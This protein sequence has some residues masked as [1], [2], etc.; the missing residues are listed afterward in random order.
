MAN[1]IITAGI[2]INADVQGAERI[3][4]L[5]QSLND[6]AGETSALAKQ[7]AQLAQQW[8][9]A[10]QNLALIEQYKA[11]KTV[12]AD[13]RQETAHTEQQMRQLAAQMKNGA[14]GAQTKQYAD[15]TAQL[16]Q[17]NE[18]K[19]ALLQNLRD[20]DQAMQTAG[21]STRQLAAQQQQF[22]QQAVQTEQGL[23][24]LNQEAQKLQQLAEAKITLGIDFDDAVR[25]EIERT[26]E[27]FERLREEGGLSQEE[28]ARATDAYHDKLRAL[29]ESLEDSAPSLME[30]VEGVTE[31]GKS[32]GGLA[33]AANE[34]M[35]FETAMA[36]VKKVTEG[37]P[38][39]YA[40]LSGSI[41]DLAGQLGIMPAELAEIAA[42]GGQMGVAMEKLPEFTRMAA[43]MSVAFG[44]SADA[45]G[46]MAAK[47]S[48][49]FGLELD[50]MTRLGD[51]IN[52]L[53][54]TTAAAESEIAQVLL[55]MGGSAKQFGLTAE[56]AAALGAAFVSLGKTPEV[57]GTAINALLQKLQNAKLGTAEFQ[58]ALKT[59]GYSA[60]SMAEQINAAPQQA[61]TDFLAKLNE[62]DN[63]TK[64]ETIGQL[65]GAEYADDIA[66]LS[67][68]LKTY[69]D[70][71]TTATDSQQTFGAMQRETDAALSTTAKR[72]DQ[73]K[74]NIA[75]AAIEMGNAL[76]PALSAT[77]AG[78]GEVAKS[79]G[80]MATRFP[81]ITQ[82]AVGF[83]AAKTA[84]TAYQ[85]AMRLSGQDAAGS[86]LKTDVGL[87]ALRQSLSRTSAAANELRL[88]L[89]AA[90]SGN[91]NHIQLHTNAVGS[92]KN[93]LTSTA[94]AAVGLWAAWEAGKGIGTS[95][96]E[97]SETVRDLGDGLGKMVAYVDAMFSER[98]FDD[99]R[100]FYR[101]SREEAKEAAAAAAKE[102]EAKAKQAAAQ[103]Q[104][105]EAQLAQIKE[106]QSQRAE[107]TEQLERNAGSLKT[108]NEAGMANGAT[109]AMLTQQNAQ[110]RDQLAAVNNQ[111]G[112]LNVNISDT[113]ALAKNKLALKELGL[114]AEQV[115]SGISQSA[116]TALDNFALA[117][118]QFGTDADSMARIFQAALQKMDSPEAVQKLKESLKSVGAE[119]GLTAEQ[120]DSIG[121]AAPA[122][123]DKVA[124]AFAKIGV[125]SAAVM[126]GISQEGKAAMDDFQAALNAAASQGI[127]DNRLLA[128]G[129]EQMMG[130][131]KS[132]EEFA[133]FKKQLNDSGNAA[134]LTAE[135][136]TRLNLAAEQGA[137]AATTAYNKLAES[138]KAAGNTAQ[139]Q[140]AG[141][142]AEQA[143]Q[144][145]EI[146][147]AQYQEMLV[148]VRERTAELAQAS[149][150]AGDEARA[151]H[152]KAS[153]AAQQRA[154]A[155]QQA[156]QA[157][158]KSSE[159]T[160]QN[161]DKAGKSIQA[162]TRQVSEMGKAVQNYWHQLNKP[163]GIYTIA[164]SMQNE[165]KMMSGAW[166]NYVQAMWHGY[167]QTR[168][169]IAD[170][171]AATQSGVGIAGKLAAAE[172]LAASNADKLDKQTLDN[173]RAAIDDARQKM[174]ALGDEAKAARA[175][176][177]KELL[178]LQGKDTAEL[179]QQQKLAKLRAARQ[180]AADAGNS[181]AVNDYNAGLAAIEQSYRIKKQQAQ[182]QAAKAAQEAEQAAKQRQ[183][184]KLEIK[185][186]DAPQIDVS[187][188]D[189]SGI[190][191]A[192]DQR[193]KA[194]VERTA[195]LLM[196]KLAQQMKA[197]T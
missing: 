87:K 5:S 52:T 123:A 131:L 8:Q 50:Q 101:T 83:A 117:A 68:S 153:E 163:T 121:N 60:E 114:T 15:L 178:Q 91:V 110:L 162:T 51:A 81:L 24:R 80:E 170:L 10:Q 169:A 185:L 70:A 99:V 62:L 74:A 93:A 61:L 167:D 107:L 14:T 41:K 7:S 173:L 73:A 105:D 132:P 4:Q 177:E 11:L 188:I 95:L 63:Q 96:R 145:G 65:F 12:L 144:R 42:A 29:E 165:A 17:L 126:S 147:A 157:T 155:E 148:R 27:A 166:A 46:D 28:L 90:L 82:L 84:L 21:I 33:Y 125:D 78:A 102:A 97:S 36:Q 109:A 9:N 18:R 168:Q 128:A 175:E 35:K 160:T 196:D 45:A 59:L 176:A 39:Q 23:M 31:I 2:E 94:Q 55:R 56:Q 86:L 164:D 154:A 34:A 26:R 38:E 143:M 72:I 192:M 122:A 124:A 58:D 161:A 89:R 79:L 134:K 3:Q 98:T 40:Q 32:A 171:N 149:A 193:D 64:S 158:E 146:S 118:Q 183:P 111:L 127:Q 104:A 142:A 141:R 130:K 119:A 112:S 22:N 75:S 85:V 150:K 66:L 43:Q 174:R 71:L 138:L 67:G 100:K 140:A 151:A 77:A 20:T 116:Q 191:Q 13:T 76:L 159:K 48:N 16:A 92:L 194:L 136:L 135:Q 152:Q 30:I 19:R 181:Q 179:E 137:S 113:S 129:F 106:L 197:R 190:T 186:P 108:L 57:A 120:I 139:L 6:A 180:A 172:N 54:N 115:T 156:T 195:A 189:L 49:V 37:T 25:T 184:E 53:G 187:Q 103:K 47:V 133:A 44:I 69:A 88:N 1:D 182:E